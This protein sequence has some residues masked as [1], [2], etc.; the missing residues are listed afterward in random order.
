MEIQNNPNVVPLCDILLVLLIIFMVMTPMTQTGIDIKLPERVGGET[1]PSTV[2]LVLEIFESGVVALNQEQFQDLN[3]LGER[4]NELFKM[5]SS[6]TI[7]VKASHKI[8]YKTLIDTVDLVKLSGADNICVIP[9]PE[10]EGSRQAIP[11]YKRY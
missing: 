10:K 6:R 2:P 11:V 9:D 7:F 8:M 5:N 1:S 3:H 4:L